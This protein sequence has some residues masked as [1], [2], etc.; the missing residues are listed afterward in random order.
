MM[1][2]EMVRLIEKVTVNISIAKRAIEG[3]HLW[4]LRMVVSFLSGR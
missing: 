1:V 4:N 3:S 2:I